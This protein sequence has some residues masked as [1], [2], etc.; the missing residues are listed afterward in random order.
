L[1]YL[2]RILGFFILHEIDFYDFKFSIISINSIQTLAP[3]IQDL[4]EILFILVVQ[5]NH[6]W[7]DLDLETI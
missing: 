3:L 7:F 6:L 1:V 4:I 2:A 5:V